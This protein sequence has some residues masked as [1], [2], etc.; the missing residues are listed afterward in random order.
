MNKRY[1]IVDGMLSGTGIRDA[2]EGGYIDP[3]QL[4][5]SQEIIGDIASWLARYE[6]AHYFQFADSEEVETLDREGRHLCERL[7]AELVNSKIE[8]FSSAKM[9]FIRAD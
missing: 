4:G 6:H 8:Y 9:A 7:R 5:I 1:L 3:E 2:V